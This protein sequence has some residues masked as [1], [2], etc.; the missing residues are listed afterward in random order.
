MARAPDLGSM[1]A[2]EVLDF[3]DDLE[4]G[5]AMPMDG[6]SGRV[7]IKCTAL[8]RGPAYCSWSAL[9]PGDGHR[10]DSL[11]VPIFVAEEG[12]PP[13]LSSIL[14]RCRDGARPV[15]GSKATTPR[16]LLAHPFFLPSDAEELAAA[17]TRTRGYF[18]GGDDEEDGTTLPYP[19][20]PGRR[21]GRRLDDA[22]E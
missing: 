18:D 4:P 13:D 19:E 17:M 1:H 15:P 14:A 16:A 7:R 8:A 3:C 20:K 21:S 22:E 9:S 6:P 11:T 5:T 12:L 2:E 10:S